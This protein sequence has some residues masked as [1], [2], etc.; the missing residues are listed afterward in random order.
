M[1]KFHSGKHNP[2]ENT[3]ALDRNRSSQKRKWTE[4]TE[5]TAKSVHFRH[6]TWLLH[7]GVLHQYTVHLPTPRKTH[8][9]VLVA[10]ETA[11][12]GAITSFLSRCPFGLTNAHRVLPATDPDDP[13]DP[14]KTTGS[15][16][17]RLMSD[18]C[19]AR[20]PP[21]L[22]VRWAFH[23]TPSLVGTCFARNTAANTNGWTV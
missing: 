6:H 12:V 8:N 15:L 18:P 21:K 9:T 13:G 17:T 19:V 7:V 16:E 4:R 22:V 14:T 1:G 23:P 20:G 11:F 2:T 5:I 10:L 3:Y